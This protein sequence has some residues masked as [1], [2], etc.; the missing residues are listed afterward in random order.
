MSIDNKDMIPEGAASVDEADLDKV[1][2]GAYFYEHVVDTPEQVVFIFSRGD[3]VYVDDGLYFFPKRCRVVRCEVYDQSLCGRY[4]YSD[5]YVVE[6]LDY[7]PGDLNYAYTR[8]GRQD[9]KMT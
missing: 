9:I 8:V 1:S 7:K 5:A 4:G 3:E 6:T 2:G